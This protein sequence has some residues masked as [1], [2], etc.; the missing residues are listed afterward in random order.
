MFVV[1]F[2]TTGSAFIHMI[3]SRNSITGAYYKNN[4][5]KPLFDNIRRQRPKSGLHAIK[6]HH[7][8]ARVHQTKHIQIFLQEQ[9][10]MVMAHP[11]YSPDLAPSDFWL[12]GYLKRQLDSYSD[13]KSLQQAATK[14]IRAIPQDEYRKTFNKWIERMQLC[15]ANKSEYFEHLM[16]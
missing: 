7:D 9:G 10:V 15:I 16:K 5:L 4:C 6:M 8:N 14:T 11:P 13:S 2:R 1:F 12:F 3:E